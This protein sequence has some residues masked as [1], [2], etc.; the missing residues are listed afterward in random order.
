[1]TRKDDELSAG[2]E[3]KMLETIYGTAGA[4]RVLSET[5]ARYASRRL[6]SWEI[7]KADTLE[8][9]S[10]KAADEYSKLLEDGET[11]LGNPNSDRIN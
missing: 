8:W 1:M 4:A 2:M 10:I 11:D 6:A 3:Q 9:D 5:A 7:E